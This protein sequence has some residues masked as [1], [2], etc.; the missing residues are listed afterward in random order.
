MKTNAI[1]RIVLYSI[2]ILLLLSILVTCVA[3]RIYTANGVTT[4]QTTNVDWENLD[5]AGI[6]VDADQIRDIDIEWVAGSI[7]I[8]P[9]DTDQIIFAESGSEKYQMVYNQEGDTLKIQYCED[10]L[11]LSW[12][13]NFGSYTSKDLVIYVPADWVCHALEIDTASANLT[14]HNLTAD[15]VSFDG[16]S[17]TCFFHD[18]TIGEMDFDTAS[19]DV[20]FTG[21]LDSLSFDAASASFKAELRNVPRSIDMDTMSGDLDITLP[22]SCGFTLSLDTMSSD[23]QTDFPTS[24]SGENWVCGDGSCRINISAMSGDVIIRKGT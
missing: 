14:V 3:F 6:A 2:A 22:A 18:C 17:G 8:Q 12:G 5:G 11:N 4:S 23:F 15:E 24:K 21:E 13:I 7:L 20:E 16:A 1:I 19:G 9:G 10:S